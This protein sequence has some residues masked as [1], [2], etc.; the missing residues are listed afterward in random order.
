MEDQRTLLDKN[1]FLRMLDVV[2]LQ[3]EAVIALGNG[4]RDLYICMNFGSLNLNS[5]EFP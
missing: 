4:S 5:I 3:F 2:A 1:G